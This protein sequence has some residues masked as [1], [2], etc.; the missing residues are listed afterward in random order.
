MRDSHA[1]T[2]GI[3]LEIAK[4]WKPSL[5]LSNLAMAFFPHFL[6]L[7][8]PYLSGKA[9]EKSL[10]LF[11]PARMAVRAKRRFFA[12]F[13]AFPLPAGKVPPT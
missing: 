10:A 1:S 9:K 13:L 12:A 7:D 8:L 6:S 5:Y 4:G 11:L 2:A 3:S